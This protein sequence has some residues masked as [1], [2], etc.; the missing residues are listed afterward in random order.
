MPDGGLDAEFEVEDQ[1]RPDRSS[2]LVDL[3]GIIWASIVSKGFVKSL[4]AWGV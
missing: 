1:S 4:G 2:I 3:R